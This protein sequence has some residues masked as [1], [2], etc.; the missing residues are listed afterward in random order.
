MRTAFFIAVIAVLVLSLRA[1]AQDQAPAEAQAP[2]ESA[3][4]AAAEAPDSNDRDASR[5]D[6][7]DF[8]VT[9]EIPAETE[10]V[11][12]VDI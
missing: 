5:D 2:P 8:I 6:D 7:I 4:P 3:E 10:L 9:E 11:F 12:P 1:T